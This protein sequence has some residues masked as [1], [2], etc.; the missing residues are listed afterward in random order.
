[1][2]NFFV[3][4]IVPC[5]KQAQFLDDSLQSV[6]EQTYQNWECIIVDDG[7]PDNVEEIANNWIKK[8]IRFKYIKKENGGL[9]SARNFGIENSLGEYVLPL[10]ADDRIMSMYIELAIDAFKNEKDLKVVYC[11]AEKFGI[12]SGEWILPEF[13]L[14]NLARLN[15]IFC[16]AVYKKADWQMSGGYDKSLR[17][18][19]E[20][21]EFWIAILKNGGLVKKINYLGFQYRIKSDSMITNLI[22]AKRKKAYEYISVKH[23]DFFVR[24]LG[25]FNFILNENRKYKV[26]I[27]KKYTSKKNI[28]N[29]F[30]KSFFGFTIFKQEKI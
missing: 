6:F 16:S 1:M 2:S 22:D 20:D 19:L 12:D 17:D 3:S 25:S 18:G 30:F 27:S 15:N 24:Q 7:S 9:S 4:I 14:D 8:D 26:E 23:A 28:I 5:F 21:W 11:K 10:D 29:L 13:S